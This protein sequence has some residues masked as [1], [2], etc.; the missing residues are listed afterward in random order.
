MHLDILYNM[1][2]FAGIRNIAQCKSQE[3]MQTMMKTNNQL[4]HPSGKAKSKVVF[5]WIHAA[6][7]HLYFHSMKE[8]GL[9]LKLRVK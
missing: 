2:F 1:K 7:L 5:N 8:T 6:V 3:K 4:R 9:I